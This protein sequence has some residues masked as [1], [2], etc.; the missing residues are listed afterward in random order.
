MIVR[1]KNHQKFLEFSK[2][3]FAFSI[4]FTL[5]KMKVNRKMCQKFS[6]CPFKHVSLQKSN[7]R[8]Y[9]KKSCCHTF[10]LS[11]RCQHRSLTFSVTQKVT[12]SLK[13]LFY[14]EISSTKNFHFVFFDFSS[15][16]RHCEV[17]SYYKRSKHER[18]N[19]A[20]SVQILFHFAYF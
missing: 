20:V 11:F 10:H 7:L 2:I 3:K 6:E 16:F 9:F 17:T 18:R 1:S 4:N 19:L 5:F 13:Y 12:Q 15:S 14:F 8:K